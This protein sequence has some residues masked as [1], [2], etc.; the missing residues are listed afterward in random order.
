M[1]SPVATE[2]GLATSDSGFASLRFNWRG[3][4]GSAG[5]PSGEIGDA[6]ADY[7]AAL[8]FM[9][10]SVDG[11]ILACGYSWG[12]LAAARVGS[13]DPRV[14]KLVL[15]APPP[16]R[17]EVERLEACAKPML[18]IAGDRDSYVPELALR[19][20]LDGVA[21]VELVILEGVDHFFMRGLDEVGHAVR[22]W[23]ER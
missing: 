5:Q 6:D 2:L 15:V 1:D 10:E 18:V 11:P 12:A 4:G 3:V 16:D 19:E 22:S 13:A 23:L 14:R 7:R 9:K 17:L 21:D 8:A 20:Q